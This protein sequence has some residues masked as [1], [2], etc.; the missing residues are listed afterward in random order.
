MYRKLYPTAKY[1]D[2]HPHLVAS[3]SN[4]GVVLES[5]GQAEQAQLHCRDALA[6]QQR[7]LRRKA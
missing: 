7:L 2:G 3:L 5:M 1:P 4:M 6:M